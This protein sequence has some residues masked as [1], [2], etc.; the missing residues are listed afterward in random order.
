[1]TT[2]AASEQPFLFVVGERDRRGR[3]DGGE[4]AA[5]GRRQLGAHLRFFAGVP[6]GPPAGLHPADGGVHAH[7]HEPIAHARDDVVCAVPGG[8]DGADHD[9]AAL[10][11][12][13]RAAIG[14]DVAL[15]LPVVDLAQ[16]GEQAA[17][18]VAVHRQDGRHV[19]DDEHA[20]I[21]QAAAAGRR[22]RPWC[23]PARPWP[24][25]ARLRS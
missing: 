7:E 22:W 15:P 25:A 23:V 6:A 21:A 17:A 4:H 20:A 10:S 13:A 16:R 9:E 8:R 18:R 24:R 12:S 1:M 5:D 11:R 19:L 14:A 2:S 3:I